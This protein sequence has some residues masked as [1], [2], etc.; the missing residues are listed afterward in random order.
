M[1]LA[2]GP[3]R[4]NDA[5]RI[6]FYPACVSMVDKIL[7]VVPSPNVKIRPSNWMTALTVK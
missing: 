5:E 2:L 6:E 4:E 7:Y 1:I 3:V